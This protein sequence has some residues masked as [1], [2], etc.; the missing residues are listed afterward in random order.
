ML[1]AKKNLAKIS[2]TPGKTRLINHFLVN[3]SWYLVDLP[4]YG[5]ARVSKE[6]RSEFQQTILNYIAKRDTLYCLYVLIDSRL[7]PQPV[8][9]K[10][11]TWLG[12]NSVPFTI[13]FTK[14]DKLAQREWQKNVEKFKKVLSENW[15]ELPPIIF[16][17]A[18]NKLG[19]EEILSS[20]QNAINK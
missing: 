4:G 17:S 19:R 1:T 3:D 8:D 16:S 12:Q 7:S 5:Y 10:F 18:I 9:V 13:V 11:I 6:M 20:I 15:E 2:T 14:T